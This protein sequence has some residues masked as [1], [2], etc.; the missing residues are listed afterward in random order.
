MHDYVDGLLDEAPD[1]MDGL[2]V[3]P[4]EN[5]LFTVRGDA[6]LLNNKCVET[7]HHLT[8]KTLYLSKRARPDLL[9]TVSFLTTRVT[10][11]NIYDWKKLSRCIK[12]LCNMKHLV[13]TLEA[14]EENLAIK[15]SVDTS[16]AVHLDMKSH[17]GVSMTLGKGSI[18]SMSRKQK[19]N[20]KSSTEVELA[21]GS[22][23]R[24]A[25]GT[26]DP[27]LSGSTG[28]CRPRQRRL[29]RQSKRYLIG[30]EQSQ[31]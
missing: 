4:A 31:I 17:L 25:N 21:F 1:D 6:E 30:K 10:K 14:E 3:T 28:I 29:P 23:R 7:F 19:I 12:Y 9:P 15:W 20:T 18:Y 5:G 16:F 22:R 13:L 26:M 27:E 2:A 24:D 8:A 11:P